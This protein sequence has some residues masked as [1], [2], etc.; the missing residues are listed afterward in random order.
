M[1]LALLL[2]VFAF[3]ALVPAQELPVVKMSSFDKPSFGHTTASLIEANEF[4]KKNGID[5]QWSFKGG[6]AANTDFATGRDKISMASALLSEA[7]RRLKGVKT[8]YLFN[9]LNLHGAILTADP[10]I[11]G[12]KDLEG[13]TLG[14]FTVT[15]NYAMLRYF[16]QK[17]GLD[18]SKVSILSTNAAGLATYLMANR[19]DAVHVWEPNYTKLIV[20]NPG[21][22]SM[23]EYVHQWEAIHGKPQRGFLGVAAHE[24]WIAENKDLIPKIY[25]TFKDL[26]DWVP[27]HHEEAAE[28]INKAAGIPKDAFLMTLQG[29]R[30]KIDVVPAGEI[31][32]NIKEVFQAGIDSGY[33]K[34]MPDDGIIYKGLKK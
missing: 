2:A 33:M 7:N 34:A 10:K 27:S 25:K 19:A 24:D 13:K 21:K 3:A 17:A 14:A 16:A 1:A 6:T 22:F 9:V 31:E 23:L 20:Q 12:L 28:V 8:V 4:D 18:L 32:A 29:N 5:I 15:T 26:A 30:Y 11:Q